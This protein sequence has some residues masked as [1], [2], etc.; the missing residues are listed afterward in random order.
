MIVHPRQWMALRIVAKPHPALEVHL[1]QQIWC[2]HLKALAGHR[3]SRRR[4]DTVRPAQDLMDGRKCRRT[5]VL[6]F[7]TA[8]DLASS[9]RRMRVSHGENALLNLTISLLLARLPTTLTVRKVF[10]RLPSVKPFIGG[11]RVNT[12]P[13]TQLPPR[14]P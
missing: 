3:A 10:A 8:H 12:E 2:R 13:S 1:P 9:P 5:L 7:Q 11:V 4:F 14:R 6:A